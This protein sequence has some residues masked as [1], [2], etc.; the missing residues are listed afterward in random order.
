MMITRREDDRSMPENAKCFPSSELLEHSLGLAH[1]NLQRALDG[2]SAYPINGHPRW[3][4]LEAL[5]RVAMAESKRQQV[6]I[7]QSEAS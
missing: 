3:P 2:I 7:A 4:D 5:I 1:G 6:A